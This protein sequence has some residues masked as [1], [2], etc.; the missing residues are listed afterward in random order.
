[1]SEK[2]IMTFLVLNYAFTALA[3]DPPSTEDE[4]EKAYQK[5]ITKEYI[6]GVY[7]PKDLADSFIQLNQLIDKESKNKFKNMSEEDA[8]RKLHFSLGRW[9]IYNWGF[10]EGSRLSVYLSNL[11]ISHPDDMAQFVIITYHRNLNKNKLEVKELIEYYE[12]KKELE[13]QKKLDQGEVIYEEKRIRPP[14][15]QNKD[16]NKDQKN[17]ENDENDGQN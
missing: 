9:I 17:D 1:M 14:D 11:G 3:Q 16:Q 4:F 12:N 5:R 13:K 2:I 15:D 7:I 8:A 6:N 10:Y